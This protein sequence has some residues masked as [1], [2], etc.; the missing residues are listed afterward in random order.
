MNTK[1][2][3]AVFIIVILSFIV[4][5]QNA[6]AVKDHTMCKDVANSSPYNPIGET[7]VF[8]PDD[9]YA[10]SWIK[11]GKM[12][13]GHTIKW[14][15]YKPNGGLYTTVSET[16]PSPESEG[17]DWWN[18]YVKFSYIRIDGY[19]PASSCGQWKIKVYAD[20][21]YLFT[22]TFTIRCQNSEPVSECDYSPKEPKTDDSITFSGSDSYDSDG[23]IDRYKW[24]LDEYGDTDEY[25]ETIKHSFDSPGYKTVRLEVEDNDGATDSTTCSVKV[26]EENEPPTARCDVEQDRATVGESVSLDSSDSYDS[27]GQIDSY[28]WDFDRD[29]ATDSYREDT[30]HSFE[31]TGYQRVELEVEDNDGATDSTTC[32]INI[33]ERAIKISVNVQNEKGKSID[34]L[35][36][37]DEQFY[38]GGTGSD[39]HMVINNVDAGSHE[40]KATKRGY[41]NGKKKVHLSPG[42]VEQVTLDLQRKNQQPK[43]KFS[44][45]PAPPT[46]GQNVVFDASASTDPDGDVSRYEWDLDGDG[47]VDKKG[48]E[49]SYSFPKSGSHAVTLDV[50]DDDNSSSSETKNLNVEKL[51]ETKIDVVKIST[52]KQKYS[53]GDK[54]VTKVEVK[55]KGSVKIDALSCLENILTPSPK[56]LHFNTKELSA[57]ENR[58]LRTQWMLPKDI[59]EGTYKGQVVC[60]GES[61][62]GRVTPDTNETLQ[63]GIQKQQTSGEEDTGKNQNLVFINPI[64]EGFPPYNPTNPERGDWLS[65]TFSVKN[66]GAKR[67]EEAPITVSLAHKRE[68]N[69]QK[70][71]IS[72]DPQE[73][74]ELTFGSG[75]R[76]NSSAVIERRW[77]ELGERGDYGLTIKLNG[78]LVKQYSIKVDKPKLV[79]N[80]PYEFE[81][82]G[83][84]DRGQGFDL[85]RFSSY[86]GWLQAETVLLNHPAKDILQ[87][88]GEGDVEE[89]AEAHYG[90]RVDPAKLSGP[91]TYKVGISLDYKHIQASFGFVDVVPFD[92]SASVTV[93]KGTTTSLGEKVHTTP[94]KKKQSIV[95]AQLTKGFE[96]ILDEAAVNVYSLCEA[97]LKRIEYS[98]KPRSMPIAFQVEIEKPTVIWFGGKLNHK[99]LDDFS[100]INPHSSKFGFADLELTFKEIR[101][102]KVDKDR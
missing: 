48:E 92:Y 79:E 74:K 14:K 23:H 61:E 60:T 84:F 91:G 18:W 67:V 29:G 2:S 71:L 47:E 93:Y 94:I 85:E 25:G 13:K 11:F 27:D 73:Q 76:D 78:R 8:S 5:A 36:Y 53:P 38:R 12:H 97:I 58:T 57:K 42:E 100:P 20:G 54:L 50:F 35:I 66:K 87:L 40:I 7:N 82:K 63:F 24:D 51:K 45:S 86:K 81:K 17:H 44:Y 101:V 39:G 68:T 69:S 72:L 59:P 10:Y 41:I 32:G 26:E 70:K 64:I 98:E 1:M 83:N 37:I 16:I 80:P 21:S 65:V 33:K 49:I 96:A 89:D 30:S 43:P 34:A 3:V 95:K 28:R 102:R 56:T 99:L 46:Q 52:D 77:Y 4:V 6:H 90:I 22:E 88:V 15:W 62:E 75:T 9:D 55:N 31:S 19:D